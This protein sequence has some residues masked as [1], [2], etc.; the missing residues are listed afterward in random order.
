MQVNLLHCLQL[1]VSL[2]VLTRAA[3][4]LAELV[5][6]FEVELG[7]LEVLIDVLTEHLLEVSV[8]HVAPSL[9]GTHLTVAQIIQVATAIVRSLLLRVEAS[10]H[11]AST[12][13]L[14]SAIIRAIHKLIS[15]DFRWAGSSAASRHFIILH[16]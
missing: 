11:L 9:L 10:R 13:N 6:L 7:A 3:A 2:R 15:L 5:V 12:A 4:Y 8:G 14:G 16:S 1:Y